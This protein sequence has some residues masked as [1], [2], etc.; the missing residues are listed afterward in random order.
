M[1]TIKIK[2]AVFFPIL[3]FIII[4]QSY[5]GNNIPPLEQLETD[6]PVI[7]DIKEKLLSNDY[8]TQS[9]AILLI[10]KIINSS[11]FIIMED[12]LICLLHH[13][14]TYNDNELEQDN[15][16]L[17][18]KKRGFDLT[19]RLGAKTRNTN[20]GNTL[21]DI[22]IEQLLNEKDIT[23][24]A[25]AI[26]ALGITGSNYEG[27][28]IKAIARAVDMWTTR[29]RN[30]D[31]NLAVIISIEKIAQ[32]NKGI[33][34]NEVYPTLI[35]IMQSSNDILIIEKTFHVIETLNSYEEM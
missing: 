20:F 28:A 10:E 1:G 12:E 3:F 32:I 17:C 22:L 11:Y 24:A 35:K 18:L 27:K 7:L 34:D 6:N 33:H 23:L 15:S 21:E 9:I 14:C 30:Q 4:S 31:F 16:H 2:R 25:S 29:T 19:G 5:S 13:L 8:F 26:F